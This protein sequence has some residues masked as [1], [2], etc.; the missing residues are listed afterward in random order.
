MTPIELLI[1]ILVFA[2][3]SKSYGKDPMVGRYFFY[4]AAVSASCS[5][6]LSSIPYPRSL[7]PEMG[8]GSFVFDIIAFLLAWFGAWKVINSK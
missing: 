6:F 5:A 1:G 8:T 7:D 3:F 4:T 2:G